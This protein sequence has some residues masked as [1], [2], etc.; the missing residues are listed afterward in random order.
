MRLMNVIVVL[1]LIAPAVAAQQQ[2]PAS[3]TRTLRGVVLTAS[4]VPLPR[5]RVAVAGVSATDPAVL[6]DERGQFAVRVQDK[7]SVRLTFTKARYAVAN[8]DM[9]RAELDAAA[10]A[11]IRVRLS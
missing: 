9:R 3:T 11:S 5:V 6:T 8:V 2:S 1:S 4:D 10:A 7:D